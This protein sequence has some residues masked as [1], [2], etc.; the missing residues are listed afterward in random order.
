MKLIQMM[1][2]KMNEFKLVNDYM[3][4]RLG[5]TEMS[6]EFK[7]VETERRHKRESSY[8]YVHMIWIVKFADDSVIASIPLNTSEKVKSFLCENI[9]QYDI[10]D[11]FFVS[12]LKDLADFESKRIFGKESCGY[13]P[14]SIF[15]CNSNTIA[16]ANENINVMRITDN[17][18]ECCD[19]IH[20]PDHCLPNGII[21][22]VVENNRIVS[23]A[24]AHKTG[25]YQ[26]IVADI[27]VDTSIDYRRKGYAR[28][29]VKFVA[30]HFIEKGGESV[31]S[32]SPDNIASVNTALA[33]GY[34]PF[35]K[36][37]A[38]TVIPE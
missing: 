32:C 31:Y 26:D 18:F 8:G 27:G 7:I 25:E 9:N 35:G 28:E 1:V 2:Y 17:S 36:S 34:K 13:T 16:S 37:I 5:A 29:C 6:R 11:N 3:L 38:F 33:A 30:R 14:S 20:F 19:D 4:F 12:Q 15:A 22:S 21:Y 23:L 24:H 10:Y